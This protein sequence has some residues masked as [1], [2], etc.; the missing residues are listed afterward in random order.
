MQFC[1]S[2]ALNSILAV[3]TKEPQGLRAHPT[4]EPPFPIST[5]TSKVP[6]TMAFGP[7]QSVCGP[8]FAQKVQVPNIE[9]S[10]PETIEGM[11]LAPEISN[12]GYLDLDHLGWQL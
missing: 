11:V 4:S 1:P 9:D 10:C 7:R 8:L 3:A 2:Q 5:W 12:I 6:Q